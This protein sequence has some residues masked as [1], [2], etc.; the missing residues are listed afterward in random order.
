MN[1]LIPILAVVSGQSLI[2]LVVWLVV[3]GLVFYILWWLIGYIGLPEPFNKVVRVVIA[4]ACALLL[5]NVLLGMVDRQFIR[6]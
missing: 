6:W 4:V 5:I 2:S 1:A 3:V